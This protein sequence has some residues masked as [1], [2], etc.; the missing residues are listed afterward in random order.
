MV[1][2]C[3]VV[4]SL[5]RVSIISGQDQTDSAGRFKI[6]HPFHPHTGREFDV[7]TWRHNWSEDRVYFH[8]DENKLRSI[9]S[10]W[11]SLVCEDPAVIVGA[12]RAHFRFAELL[13]LATML[14]ELRV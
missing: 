12:G 3:S 14:K 1:H 5:I 13:E 11:T 8:D 10:Q 2:L 6:T 4:Y 9:P 7:V